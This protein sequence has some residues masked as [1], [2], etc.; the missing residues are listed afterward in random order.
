MKDEIN[1]SY[2]GGGVVYLLQS[3]LSRSTG[4]YN[5][6]G[7]SYLLQIELSTSTIQYTL[8][9]PPPSLYQPSLIYRLSI[10]DVPVIGF[11][12][13]CKNQ[14]PLKTYFSYCLYA[15]YMLQRSFRSFLIFSIRTLTVIPVTFDKHNH[16]LTEISFFRNNIKYLRTKI[17][18]NV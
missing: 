1:L 8:I 10:S 2:N 5:G 9:P 11:Q 6:G 3:E 18:I 17:L 4:H 13:T 16:F 15:L 7:V 14:K 12:V